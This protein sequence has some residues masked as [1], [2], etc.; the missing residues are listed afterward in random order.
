[1]VAETPRLATDRLVLRRWDV[2]GDLDAYAAICA[3]P[4]VM[5]FIGDGATRN[6][7][8]CAEQ[9]ESFEQVWQE[10]SFGLFALELAPTREL[11]GFT[12]LAIPDFLP[13]IMPAV[14]IGWRLGRA[15]WGRGYAT[16]AATAVLAFGFE[17]VGL[18]RI[19]SVHA[20]GNDAS[21]NVMR[22]IGMHLDRETVHPAH[23]FPVRVYVINRPADTT[24][25]R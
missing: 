17:R 8:Q 22:K 20:A 4:E 23:G 2:N 3:D 18:D 25:T 19:V 16:E 11:I 9:L 12:G 5:R 21:G 6:R 15:H 10:R 1:V 13:E 7:E 14:E 24:P